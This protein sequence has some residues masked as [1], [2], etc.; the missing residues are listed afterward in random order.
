MAAK[1]R[2]LR[3]QPHTRRSR[4]HFEV[5]KP[6]EPARIVSPA[7]RI[8]TLLTLVDP[9]PTAAVPRWLSVTT[10]LLLA[11]RRTHFRPPSH[12]TVVLGKFRQRSGCINYLYL[13]DRSRERVS[14]GSLFSS[15]GRPNT[16]LLLKVPQTRKHGEN[17]HRPMAPQRSARGLRQCGGM[18]LCSKV[19]W[20]LWIACV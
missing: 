15:T 8:A 2:W 3:S 18:G 7:A 12:S 11:S 19:R 16:D 14:T 10:D 4:A 1:I 9:L 20:L 13:G 6:F 5:C 17:T